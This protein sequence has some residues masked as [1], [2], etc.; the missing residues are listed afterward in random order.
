MRVHA[1]R[2]GASLS[3]LTVLAFGQSLNCRSLTS[4]RRD[5]GTVD[6]IAASGTV[7]DVPSTITNAPVA[8]SCPPC[9]ILASGGGFLE[10]VYWWN[11]TLGLTLDTVSVVITQYNDTAITGR[12][13]VYGDLSSVKATTVSE[14]LDIQYSIGAHEYS[15]QPSITFANGTDGQADPTRSIPYPTPYLAAAGYMYLE[16]TTSDAGC[17][18]NAILD[19]EKKCACPM[20]SAQVIDYARSIAKN[21]EV[22]LKQTFYSIYPSDDET[23]WEYIMNINS[24]SFDAAPYSSWM[25]TLSPRPSKFESCY[26]PN[27][28]IGPPALKIPVTALTA[29]TTAT[30][31]GTESY[32]WAAATPANTASPDIPA[33]TSKAQADVLDGSTDTPTHANG[34][35]PSPSASDSIDSHD[36]STPNLAEPVPGTA[37]VGATNSANPALDGVNAP[38]LPTPVKGSTV[39]FAHEST[40]P[41]IYVPIVQANSAVLPGQVVTSAGGIIGGQPVLTL[42]GSAH[43]MDDSSA[44]VIGD[45]T[46][47]QG[48]TITVGG[49]V[50]SLPTGGSIAIVNG[51]TQNLAHLPIAAAAEGS[52]PLLTL[53]G[54]TYTMSGSSGFV[55]GDQTLTQGGAIIVSGS[56]VSLPTGGSIAIMN[57]ATQTLAHAPITAVARGSQPLLTLGG[58]TYTMSGTSEFVIGGQTLTQGGAVTVSGSVVSLPTGGSIAIVNGATQSLAYASATAAA[59]GGAM[60]SAPSFVVID[61]SVIS[62][63]G[64]TISMD[65]SSDLVLGDKTISRGGVFTTAGHTISL[66]SDEAAIVIDGITHTR[67]RAVVSPGAQPLSA[68]TVG[69]HLTTLSGSEVVIGSSTR[70]LSD[71]VPTSSGT[72][73]SP[74]NTGGGN[75][76]PFTGSAARFKPVLWTV[77]GACFVLKM[78]LSSW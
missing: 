11:S 20:T 17:P 57:G 45:Q 68:H 54:S 27:L 36:E 14:A 59:A 35:L 16:M 3:F 62:V 73:N 77:L 53:G 21:S 74:S 39:P 40:V 47:A 1:L 18:A 78:M 56:V 2:F 19:D 42:G 6:E 13:T 10:R 23:N 61:Q 49:S 50:I 31:Q 38:V 43:T 30:V 41:E 66:P 75:G 67:S 29:T 4:S 34:P 32:S 7:K 76:I 8:S 64:S 15:G 9:Q 44:F 65:G 22:D 33:E 63:L 25:A 72:V 48:S 55:V 70:T 46:L 71:G 60:S 52:R 5:L 12:T 26:F 51:A 24:K 69:S 37:A 28:F 58:S